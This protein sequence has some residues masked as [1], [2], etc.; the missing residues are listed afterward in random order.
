MPRPMLGLRQGGQAPPRFSMINALVLRNP[1]RAP[2][3]QEFGDAVWLMPA[4]ALNARIAGKSPVLAGSD[5][6]CWRQPFL[7]EGA[8]PMAMGA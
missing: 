4:H 2:S 7:R 6:R 5:K 8:R 3:G 1:Y